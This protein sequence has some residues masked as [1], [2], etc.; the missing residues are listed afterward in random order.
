MSQGNVGTNRG[1][2]VATKQQTGVATT[3]KMASAWMAAKKQVDLLQLLLTQG[4]SEY[5]VKDLLSSLSGMVGAVRARLYLI[6][7]DQRFVECVEE[8][9]AGDAQ[10]LKEEWRTVSVEELPWLM[11]KLWASEVLA[12]AD[13]AALG[14]EAGKEAEVFK[15]Q[16]LS[17]VVVVPLQ[18]ERRLGG[19]L[20]FDNVGSLGSL[21]QVGSDKVFFL[22]VDK[23]GEKLI[24]KKSVV[25]GG[26]SGVYGSVV[27]SIDE[28]IM[29]F[30][31]GGKLTLVN[32][33]F[34]GMFGRSRGDYEG[35]SLEE[36]KEVF[37]Q[38]TVNLM[39]RNLGM[40]R[41]GTSVV[42]FE[43]IQNVEGGKRF[44]EV[45]IVPLLDEERPLGELVLFRDVTERREVEEA[46]VQSEKRLKTVLG[47]VK[48]G[49]TF[50]DE[51]GKFLIFN[52]EMEELT[53]YSMAEANGGGEFIDLIHPEA[54]DKQRILGALSKMHEGER[55]VGETTIKTKDGKVKHV[56]VS[57]T[58][59]MRD[60][61]QRFLSAYHD[62][63]ERKRAK[64]EL[65]ARNKQLE[66][67]TSK[68]HTTAEELKEARD[69][70]EDKVEE[71]TKQLSEKMLEAEDLAKFSSED[72]FPVI[73]I[74]HDGTILYANHASGA[75]LR[76][77]KCKVGNKVPEGWLKEVV[78]VF[79][80]NNRKIVE[81]ELLGQT[82]SFV[83][84]PVKKNGYVNLYGRDVTH[85]KEVEQMK[86]QFISMVSHQLRTPLT[87]VR[88]YSGMLLQGKE[89]LTEKQKENA[90]IIHETSVRLAELVTDLLSISRMESGRVQFA[91]VEGDLVGLIE[92]VVKELA[93]LAQQG[94]VE[95]EFM[96]DQLAP[97]EFDPKLLKE[98][99]LNLLSNAIK[100]TPPQGKAWVKVKA[101][102]KKV[103]VEVGDTGMG[104]PEAAQKDVFKRFYRAQNVVDREIEGTG[105]GLAVARMMVEKW[106]GKI[107]FESAERKGSKFYFTIPLGVV[108]QVE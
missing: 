47:A 90:S 26:E 4:D 29:A 3:E 19:F 77:W 36:L 86:N 82:I 85:E 96:H 42:P 46:V 99:T 9:C 79:T 66:E 101:D 59:I 93:P 74:A 30:T 22:A 24:Q 35:K 37:G 15:R 40:V 49:I 14:P 27:E 83:I 17:Q 6:S 8:W 32:Q 68:L 89:P 34:L 52:P 53:G 7:E 56:L 44:L 104:I 91:P 71:K 60:G 23:L 31:S 28:G 57:T 61:K 75:L 38:D 105:L 33:K 80:S 58:V 51:K 81:V 103:V 5:L 65:V 13:L 76:E 98:V 94:Q 95:V 43:I 2:V 54:E 39:N 21:A 100:Y 97:F 11:K 10:S 88:W 1:E 16:M 67:M 45:G 25:K 41:M 102:T 92:G 48:E 84:V 50:S 107:W 70:L 72:P 106:G 64:D 69:H 18:M 63:T 87:S 62:I 78:E 12:V 55:H 73:R 108:E 20:Q